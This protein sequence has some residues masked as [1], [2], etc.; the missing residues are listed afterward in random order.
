PEPRAILDAPAAAAQ[1]D[2]GFVTVAAGGGGVPVVRDP[3]GTLR[4][5]EAV[6]DKDLAAALLAAA[7]AV[8]VLV[9]ATDV[10]H[11]LVGYGTPRPRPLRRTT[12][13]ELRTLAGGGEFGSGSMGP[14]VQ[15]LLRFVDRGGRR[16]VITSLD[17]IGDAVEG[18]AGT[19]LERSG[20]EGPPD[21]T[22]RT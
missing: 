2:A 22:E 13:E 9:I 1:L 11:V 15:A 3:D 4:G 14:K 16:A 18:R 17:R 7:L 12:A 6:V 20:R 21:H 8:D 5:V 19:V 10:E